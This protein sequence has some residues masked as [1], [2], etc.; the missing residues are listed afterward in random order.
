MN[1]IISA[2]FFGT[3]LSIIDHAGRKWLTAEEV[4]LALGY[5]EANARIG[6]SNLYNRHADEFTEGDDTCVINLNWRG[7]QRELRVFS[8][9]GCNLL[10]FFSSTP[11]AKDF[12]A[13]AKQMLAGRLAVQ[14]SAP[15]TARGLIITR[16]VERQVLERF[17]AGM[18][19][20]QIVQEMKIS[21]S[22]VNRLLHGK[23]QFSL[24][25]GVP[26]CSPELIAAVAARHLEVEQGR[27]IEAQQRIAQKYLANAHNKP[28]A[29]AL[30]RVGQH[31]QQAPGIAMLPPPAEG[32]EQ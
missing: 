9:N 24:V 3:P 10:G 13:W 1:Q 26:E 18:R 19:Q 23:Y 5:A 22:A 11:R 16:S 14:P 17:V 20:S 25:A 29:D 7:Q 6:I 15:R 31:L 4:G 12:R 21:F 27:L 32:G 8:S 28:L 2:E 30:D